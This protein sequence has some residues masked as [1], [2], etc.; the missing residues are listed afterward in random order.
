MSAKFRVKEIVVGN[1]IADVDK[2]FDLRSPCLTTVSFSRDSAA[3]IKIGVSELKGTASYAIEASAAGKHAR[4]VA[5]VCQGHISNSE[6]IKKHE[7]TAAALLEA[8]GD[9]ELGNV[10]L[11]VIQID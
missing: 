6:Y 2:K 3:I 4:L 9:S 1:F 5:E 11:S 8:L 10:S 7:I